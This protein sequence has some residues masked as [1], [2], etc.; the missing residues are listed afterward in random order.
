MELT[1]AQTRLT[2]PG[3]I[4]A[5]YLVDTLVMAKLV[6]ACAKPKPRDPAT[7]WSDVGLDDP[8]QW[9]AGRNALLRACLALLGTDLPDTETAGAEG[10]EQPPAEKTRGHGDT[11]PD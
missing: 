8:A 11:S 6:A 4:D 2:A 1:C 7:V 5:V 9:V 10:N 3:V